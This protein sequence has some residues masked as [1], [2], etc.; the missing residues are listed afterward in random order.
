VPWLFSRPA[1]RRAAEHALV[2]TPS[3]N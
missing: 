2:L 1:V 3:Q